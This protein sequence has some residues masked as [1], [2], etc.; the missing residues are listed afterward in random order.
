MMRLTGLVALGIGL[1]ILSSIP[2]AAPAKSLKKTIKN[3]TDKPANDL[4]V[5]TTGDHNNTTHAPGWTPPRL[6]GNGT[7]C[8]DWPAGSGSVPAGGSVTVKVNT[9]HSG[10]IDDKNTYLTRNDTALTVNPCTC[11][12]EK[13][14][15]TCLWVVDGNNLQRFSLTPSGEHVLTMLNREP[16]PVVYTNVKVW[17]HNL[18]SNGEVDSLDT[19][20]IPTGVL[21]AAIPSVIELLAFQDTTFFLEPFAPATYDLFVADEMNTCHPAQESAEI[22]MADV[23]TSP[24]AV[25]DSPSPARFDMFPNYPNPFNPNTT[26]GY[27]I[28]DAGHVRL[29][30]YDVEGRLLATLVDEQQ[31]AGHY[32]STWEGVDSSGKKLA[33]GTYFARLEFAG[34]VRS[35]TIV[36][37]K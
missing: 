12:C 1:C 37:L 21:S 31:A 3:P 32:T 33:S 10:A 29:E 35:R 8:V 26:I 24:S 2:G 13:S 5:C 11:G 14:C 36:L 15:C 7:Y 30:I 28:P 18:N 34:G 25:G 6:N 23:P 22:A 17:V 20:D 27:R 16:V 9:G 19:F 4:H